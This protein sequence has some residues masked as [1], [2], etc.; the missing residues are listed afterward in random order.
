MKHMKL[1]LGVAPIVI[2]LYASV[3]ELVDY[4]GTCMLKCIELVVLV[5][6]LSTHLT[7]LPYGKLECRLIRNLELKSVRPVTNRRVSIA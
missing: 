7:R 6:N 2:L 5:G 1:P 4:A 3:Q